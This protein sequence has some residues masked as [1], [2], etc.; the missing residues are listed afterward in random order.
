MRSICRGDH[1]KKRG[2]PRAAFLFLLLWAFAYAGCRQ[3]QAGSDVQ[4]RHAADPRPST[5]SSSADLP[6]TA[7]ADVGD[8]P[9]GHPKVRFVDPRYD[10]GDVEAGDEIE[11]TFPF[12]NAGD[13]PLLL[14]R[15]SGGCGCTEAR[16]SDQEIP[17]GRAGEIRATLRTQGLHG[18]VEKG[19]ILETNDPQNP[20]VR[21][22]ISG[23]VVSEVTVEP[24][25]LNWGTFPPGEMPQPQR[26][27]IG[28][29]EGRGLRVEKVLSESP[30]VLL[31]K[32]SEDE[33]GAVY[34]VALAAGLPAGRFAGRITV[35]SNSERVPEVH[36]PFQ[37][38]VQGSVRVTP[39]TVSLGS[40][41]AGAPSVHLLNVTKT[42]EQG[43]TIEKV[44]TTSKALS[45]EILEGEQGAR[46]GIKVTYT[47]RRGAHGRI[48]ERITILVNDGTAAFLEVPVYGTVDGNEDKPPPIP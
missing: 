47:P 11:H 15:V 39:E 21:L 18:T 32:E 24:R 46:Y 2:V 5:S 33:S 22:T 30:A 17:P 26:I 4:N 19:L 1:S 36:V 13:A 20:L 14:N 28:L 29:A 37:G 35:R 10:F 44:K 23:R 38:T 27:R 25:Y 43:F 6:G 31:M 8:P 12:E 45:T 40:V 42:G 34:A 48:A 3:E 41:T 7:S 16:V 9:A